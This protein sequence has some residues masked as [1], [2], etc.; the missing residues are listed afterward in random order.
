MGI[1]IGVF[2]IGTLVFTVT[3]ISVAPQVVMFVGL[4]HV[5]FG[6]DH[7]RHGGDTDPDLPRPGQRR[8]RWITRPLIGW[9]A[10]G[11]VG[12]IAVLSIV[13]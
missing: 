5:T 3:A 13:G 9:M 8:F 2:A 4:T 10:L 7:V 6:L 11:L 12:F 1:V